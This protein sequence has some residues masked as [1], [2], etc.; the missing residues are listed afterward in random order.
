VHA[1]LETMP[2]FLRRMQP[3]ISIFLPGCSVTPNLCN[4]PALVA[5]ETLAWTPT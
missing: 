2:V 5:P 4:S 3:T 1:D